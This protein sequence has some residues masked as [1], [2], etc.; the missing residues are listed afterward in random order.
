MRR[1]AGRKLPGETA[2]RPPG[3]SALRGG[4]LTRTALRL[5]VNPYQRAGP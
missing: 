5:R 4:T 2:A 3:R 1:L